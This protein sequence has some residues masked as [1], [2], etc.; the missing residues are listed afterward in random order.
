MEAKE[1]LFAFKLVKKESAPHKDE[2]RK[3]EARD[4][5]ATAG[6]SQVEYGEYRCDFNSWRDGGVYC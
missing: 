2:D 3:W 1:K 5:V 4:G 6:C